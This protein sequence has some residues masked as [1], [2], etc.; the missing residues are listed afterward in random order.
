M[1]VHEDQISR[2]YDRNRLACADRGVSRGAVSAEARRG[3]RA[4]L[5]ATRA[6][7]LVRRGCTGAVAGPAAVT[8]A[9]VGAGSL[10]AALDVV[11]VGRAST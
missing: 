11:R 7:A 10:A 3:G 4:A 5:E 2:T 1:R 8:R 9:A 6:G